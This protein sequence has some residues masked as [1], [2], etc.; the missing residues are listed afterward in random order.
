M[1]RR[2]EGR[3]EWVAIR[4]SLD[5]AEFDKLFDPALSGPERDQ[6]RPDDQGRGRAGCL[7]KSLLAPGRV[8]EVPEV[9]AHR[10]DDSERHGDV[11]GRA[12]VTQTRVERTLRD[13]AG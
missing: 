1:D 2:R 7:V 5:A 12:L 6:T 9:P 8:G 13:A 10:R 4:S 11:A 3:E